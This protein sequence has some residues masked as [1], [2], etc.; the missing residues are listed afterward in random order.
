MLSPGQLCPEHRHPP[1]DGGPGEEE[2]F[3]CGGGHSRSSG[4]PGRTSCSAPVSGSRSRPTRCVRF[5]GGSGG[6][7]R[8]RSSR[9]RAATTSTSSPTRSAA[10]DGRSLT[11][12]GCPRVSDCGTRPPIAWP[13]TRSPRAGRRPPSPR[14]SRSKT[15]STCR[16]RDCGS[17]TTTRSTSVSRKAACASFKACR[18]AAYDAA[19]EAAR[20][21]RA[22]VAEAVVDSVVA[23]GLLRPLEVVGSR[24]SRVATPA[25]RR[26]LRD[27]DRARGR[28]ESGSRR[29]DAGGSG[30]KDG[31]CTWSCPRDGAAPTWIFHVVDRRRGR[32]PLCPPGHRSLSRLRRDGTREQRRVFDL[33]RRGPDRGARW[34]HRLHPRPRRDRLPRRAARRRGD[35]DRTRC[36]GSGRRASS[37]STRSGGERVA[38]EARSILVGYDYE[39]AESV[40]LPEELRERLTR[41][42]AAPTTAE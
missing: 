42:P 26:G 8:S 31:E 12:G 40:P 23:S 15:S 28:S 21:Q 20:Q 27:R 14:R 3:R 5:P 19:A 1:F 37:W 6:R 34:A 11:R 39:L 38:A 2:T 32:S 33:P 7:R 24:S 18:L 9:R 36:S 22:A 25:A 35:R 30:E 4:S 13:L 41:P 10:G 17:P 29:G 16:V